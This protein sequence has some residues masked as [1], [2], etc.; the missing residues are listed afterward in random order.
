MFWAFR[1]PF[2]YELRS[3][4]S[5]FVCMNEAGLTQ[6]KLI[7]DSKAFGLATEDRPWTAGPAV[8]QFMSACLLRYIDDHIFVLVQDS[9]TAMFV[10]TSLL[11]RLRFDQKKNENWIS[12]CIF[13]SCAE[14]FRVFF[15]CQSANFF[16]KRLVFAY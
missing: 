16:I 5:K 1:R 15:S 6:P 10:I 9:T 2:S 13:K 4:G 7:L 12:H 3:I 14:G 11:R 8:P